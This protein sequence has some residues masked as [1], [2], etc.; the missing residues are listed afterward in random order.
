MEAR[1]GRWGRGRERMFTGGG[2]DLGTGLS[3]TQCGLTATEPQGLPTQPL[4]SAPARQGL[5]STPGWASCSGV[6]MVTEGTIRT[7]HSHLFLHLHPRLCAPPSQEGFPTSVATVT[8]ADLSGAGLLSLALAP[9][10]F[11]STPTPPPDMVEK[12]VNLTSNALGA[13]A[14]C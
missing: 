7:P 5:L 9:P 11:S 12:L 13:P 2:R 3:E 14:V 10:S 8:R 1:R 6:T 4:S